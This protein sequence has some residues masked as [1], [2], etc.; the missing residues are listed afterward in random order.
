MRVMTELGFGTLSRG[1]RSQ[2]SSCSGGLTNGYTQPDITNNNL[3]NLNVN[4]KNANLGTNGVVSNGA[5][6]GNGC[7]GTK[8]SNQGGTSDDGIRTVHDG[9]AT[10]RAGGKRGRARSSPSVVTGEGG[11]HMCG[12]CNTRGLGAMEPLW[13]EQR[14][15][16]GSGGVVG[17]PTTV[18]RRDRPTMPWWEVATRRSRYRSCPAF[19]QA[20]MVNALEQTMNTVTSKLE[21][22]ASSP[23]LKD[24]EAAELRRTAAVLRQQSSAVCQSVSS[25]YFSMERQ[26]STDSVSSVNSTVSTASCVSYA[27]LGNP[28]QHNLQ[29]SLQHSLQHTH[30]FQQND[31]NGDQDP[32]KFKKRSWLRS[33]FRRAFGRQNRKRSKQQQE[34]DTAQVTDGTATQELPLNHATNSAVRQLPPP[35]PP[36]LPPP[37]LTTDTHSQQYMHSQ[38][39]VKESQT[40]SHLR[41]EVAEKER[42]L[43]DCRLEVL[44]AQS[45]LQVQAEHINRLQTEC[46]SL[47][48]EN[49]RLASL[50]RGQYGPA[51]DAL[52]T[53]LSHT[54]T[55]LT[56]SRMNP[57]GSSSSSVGDG[58]RM[59]IVVIDQPYT[60]NL[61]ATSLAL[62]NNT[63]I[64]NIS[65][66]PKTTWDQLDNLVNITLKDYGNRV[67]PVS[68][69]GLEEGSIQCYR[70]AEA[71][72]TQAGP[73]PELLPYGYCVGEVD[74]LHCWLKDG[75]FNSEGTTQGSCAAA[76]FAS[77]TPMSVL[78]R[79][80]AHL[81]EHRRLVLA[82]PPQIGKTH[83]AHT[84][85]RYYVLNAGKELTDGAIK[86][87]NVTG[88]NSLEL[89]QLLSSVWPHGKA[90]VSSI[91]S[92]SSASSIRSTSSL[93][94][95]SSS[96]SSSSIS[97]SSMSSSSTV[98]AENLNSTVTPIVIIIDDLHAAG[99]VVE[100]L[101]RCL[102]AA[103]HTGPAIIATSQP[104]PTLATRLHIHCNFRWSSLSVSQ[105]PVRGV[106][107]R[108]LRQ[109][110]VVAEVGSGTQLPDHHQLAEWL[111]RLWLHL[112]T[113]LTDH[114]ASPEVA[115]IGPGML[116]DCPLGQEE[117]QVWFTEV[118]NERVIP[119]LRSLLLSHGS[120]ALAHN[121]ADPLDWVLATYP[122]P[123]NA[124]CGPDHLTR[125]NAN[126]VLSED[127]KNGNIERNRLAIHRSTSTFKHHAPYSQGQKNESVYAV[128]HA[129]PRS[130]PSPTQ[131]PTVGQ[132]VVTQAIIT[133]VQTATQCI[134][135]PRQGTA[136]NLFVPVQGEA[137]VDND[138]KS[139]DCT[140][141]NKHHESEDKDVHM[142]SDSSPDIVVCDPFSTSKSMKH[143][144]QIDDTAGVEPIYSSIKEADIVS[145]E[146]DS[147]E[148][149][150][151]LKMES[152]TSLDV[153]VRNAIN[154]IGGPAVQDIK[155]I[156]DTG[157]HN[158]VK[159]KGLAQELT[160]TFKPVETAI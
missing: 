135:S 146:T 95:S 46:T 43:T 4:N 50:V 121:W 140:H 58:R 57:T 65:I 98:A 70:V 5:C 75:S 38:H 155:I 136:H 66:E 148:S 16:A 8:D 61:G 144:N 133:P 127:T 152:H 76:A 132:Q 77:A 62:N 125:L 55:T 151:S 89:C 31:L 138:T 134:I 48:E 20:S 56:L 131:T 72:R 88:S 11:G 71:L 53:P 49:T 90:S 137:H 91:R 84:L 143:N 52:I 142:Q 112:N 28:L 160:T 2:S 106:L 107:G 29:H 108:V 23:D 33:S 103:V 63:H 147:T 18:T 41:A 1:R 27:S 128:P 24:V 15:N 96:S 17:P 149:A 123:P 47:R 36:P 117:A 99:G 39:S 34:Q 116:M 101:Q 26:L 7:L 6:Q 67:D 64:G 83:I 122:W 130:S 114:C 80:S 40:L 159:M 119:A 100:L 68:G 12:G 120:P 19:T 74:A 111:T 141:K 44:S 82:G 22:L 3:N 150:D 14:G 113:I 92:T 30:K 21:R 156:R 45:Q 102:S 37:L 69:L 54:F 94:S 73:R 139:D 9:F 78:Q 115:C 79:L 81:V 157:N 13:E 109:R 51:A 10:I 105:E 118:W 154:M 85:A 25:G 86:T 158:N 129:V 93:A 124:A 110:V 104:T 35:A 60:S 126:D 145:M 153:T 59:R 97:T 87:F 42:V 32:N